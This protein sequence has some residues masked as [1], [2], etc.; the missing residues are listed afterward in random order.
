MFPVVGVVILV[1]V[2][3]AAYVV[4]TKIIHENIGFGEQH[5]LINDPCCWW[6]DTYLIA[7]RRN[8]PSH[9][10]KCL[11]PLLQ[12]YAAYCG[13]SISGVERMFSAI[14]QIT[15]KYR[16]SLKMSDT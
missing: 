2:V 1:V 10:S 7:R 9:S 6:Q 12:R 8:R 16:N 11:S 15:G 3:V 14:D 13:T 5:V 4:T